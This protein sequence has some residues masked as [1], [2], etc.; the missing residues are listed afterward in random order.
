[1][2]LSKSIKVSEMA[3]LSF[4]LSFVSLFAVVLAGIN[5]KVFFPV[6]LIKVEIMLLVLLVLPGLILGLILG[7]VT[8][9]GAFIPGLRRIPSHLPWIIATICY[10]T[11]VWYALAYNNYL[12]KA[13][14]KP[15]SF[16][17]PAVF[18]SVVLIAVMALAMPIMGELKKVS[19]ILDLL[20]LLIM[21]TALPLGLAQRREM[22]NSPALIATEKFQATGFKV[23]F[24]GIDGME[25][26]IVDQLVAEGK[27]PNL[28][29]LI[30]QGVR[31]PLTTLNPTHSPQIWTTIV[32]G[33]SPQEH[34]IVHYVTRRLPFTRVETGSLIF[35]EKMWVIGLK[36]YFTKEPEILPINSSNRLEKAL[37]NIFSEHGV[38]S[39]VIHWWATW[40]AEK[41]LGVMVSDRFVYFRPKAKRGFEPPP[42]GLT[43]PPE[44]AQD[45]ETLVLP[46]EEV[47]NEFYHRYLDV[48]DEEIAKMRNASYK[49]YSV[50][51]EF[52][53]SISW[54]VSIENISLDLIRRHPEISF[55][56]IYTR[57]IDILS[58]TA[59][60]YSN[61][62]N[63]PNISEKQR[64]KYG[65][66]IDEIY[67]DNDKFIG[68]L[69]K[70][71]DDRTIFIV[72]SDHGWQKDP[73]GKYSH[74]HAPPGILVMAGGPIQKGAAIKQPTVYDL[75][76]NILY[77]M[78][79]P[80]AQDM[81]GR[82]WLEG[83]DHEF[84]K[85]HP[86]KTVSTYGTY[87]PMKEQKTDSRTDMEIKKHLRALG[88]I[89]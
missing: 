38:P 3:A 15:V 62:I 68:E 80:T 66:I 2:S 22:G 55:W 52:P 30:E 37:W 73:D 64:N 72:A 70:F 34:G 18:L 12:L 14:T 49:K 75:T 79:F 28:Q 11:Q 51:S 57:G 27:M 85:S 56:A 67:S 45:L 58:H 40:P 86:V 63:D 25:N 47:S 6:D 17:L 42:G 20:L 77:L 76:P 10:L 46:P 7:L 82:V 39:G 83:Y 31:S 60:K 53:F 81:R 88:Y 19:F 33:K 21:L 44:L 29:K 65:R 59:F 71:A 43:Y 1:M 74:H 61:R 35:P 13:L 5:S 26:K 36:K 9:L 69:L 41:I 32:T 48:T 24:L 23:I 54:D 87:Q 78:G 8:Y 50:K 4:T 16:L 89:K 84:V